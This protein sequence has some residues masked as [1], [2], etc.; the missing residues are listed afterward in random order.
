LTVFGQVNHVRSG[1]V[2]DALKIIPSAWDVME[3]DARMVSGLEFHLIANGRGKG[4]A[5]SKTENNGRD[6][7]HA[8]QDATGCMMI[9]GI[10]HAIASYSRTVYA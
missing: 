6:Q 5:R 9:G 2:R 4:R 8:Q 1:A 3:G 10:H 7:E